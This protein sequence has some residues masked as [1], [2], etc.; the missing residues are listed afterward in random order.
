[1]AAGVVL[2]E[3]TSSLVSPGEESDGGGRRLSPEQAATAATVAAA[4][5]HGLELT[6]PNG[7]PASATAGSPQLSNTAAHHVPLVAAQF[8]D[9]SAAKPLQIPEQRTDLPMSG[10]SDEANA[11]LRY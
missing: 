10:R 3:M 2:Y 11:C 8:D 9:D 1:M 5:A 6:G 4:K 7:L